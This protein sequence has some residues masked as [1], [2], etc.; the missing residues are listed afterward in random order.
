MSPA[1]MGAPAQTPVARQ[2]LLSEESVDYTRIFSGT[3]LETQTTSHNLDIFGTPPVIEY[4]ADEEGSIG[5]R[6]LATI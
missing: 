3:R 4:S 6:K 1:P 2:D 5:K